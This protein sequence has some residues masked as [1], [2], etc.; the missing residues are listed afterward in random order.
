MSLASFID[1]TDTHWPWSREFTRKSS[2]VSQSVSQSE[3]PTTAVMLKTRQ[4][5]EFASLPSKRRRR[6]SSWTLIELQ[7]PRFNSKRRR[8]VNLFTLKM[9]LS[10]EEQW[11]PLYRETWK[12]CQWS[13]LRPDLVKVHVSLHKNDSLSLVCASSLWTFILRSTT[14]R[15]ETKFHFDTNVAEKWRWKYKR[16][17]RRRTRIYYMCLYFLCQNWK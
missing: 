1:S 11:R 5:I 13:S 7:F 15:K 4:L 9:T 3:S 14:R 12:Q 6:S 17:R 8:T 10:L 16:E 2:S